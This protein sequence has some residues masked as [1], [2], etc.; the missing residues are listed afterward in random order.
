MDIASPKLNRQDVLGSWANEV[1]IVSYEMARPYIGD[2]FEEASVQF[3]GG[4][5]VK[6]QAN[7]LCPDVKLESG[8][9][10]E[11]K[12]VGVGQHSVIY[13]FRTRNYKRMLQTGERLLY[14]F[15]FHHWRFN[16]RRCMMLSALRKELAEKVERVLLVPARQVHK[17][18]KTAPRR[19]TNY[20]RQNLA[21]RWK[22]KPARTLGRRHFSKWCSGL[23]AA[24]QTAEVYGVK[25]CEVAV[26]HW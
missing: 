11:V 8:A 19:F 16:Q 26:M 10:L 23:L 13:E 21:L 9:Y 2:F 6:T 15:W 12:S 1:E 7:K 5:R 24:R 25:T 3:F 18:L 4:W 20:T 14:A 17:Q 22:L